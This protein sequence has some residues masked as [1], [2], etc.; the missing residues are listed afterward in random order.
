MRTKDLHHC[1]KAIFLIA[2]AFLSYTPKAISQYNTWEIKQPLGIAAVPR[3]GAVSFTIGTK[4]YVGT[5]HS[6]T[7]KDFW[8]YDPATDTWTQKAD[9]GGTGRSDAV[10]FTI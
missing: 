9:F 3:Y 6:G 8:E 10:A 1:L 4:G 2:F 7:G 5:G